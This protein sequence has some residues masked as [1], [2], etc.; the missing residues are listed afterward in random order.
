MFSQ[1]SKVK[2]TSMEIGTFYINGEFVSPKG[3]EKNCVNKIACNY[4][5]EIGFVVAGNEVDVDLA[6]AAE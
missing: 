2:I 5:E 1:R 4:E 3:A 6:E